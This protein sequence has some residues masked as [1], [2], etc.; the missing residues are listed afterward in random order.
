MIWFLLFA[1]IVVLGAVLTAM[2]AYSDIKALS[3]HAHYEWHDRRPQCEP[4]APP[5]KLLFGATEVYRTSQSAPSCTTTEGFRPSR[6][7]PPENVNWPTT[8]LG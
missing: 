1:A 6:P 8:G 3:D 4:Q 5:S 2:C 7:V